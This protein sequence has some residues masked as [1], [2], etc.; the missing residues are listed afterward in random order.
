MDK[1]SKPILSILSLIT[2][3][4]IIVASYP[5]LIHA[6]FYQKE[7]DNWQVQSNGQ[8][9]INLFC[10]V[11]ALLIAAVFTL[12]NK[13]YGYLLWLGCLL[14]LVYT[15]TI[16]CFNIHF[17]QYFLI[18]CAILGLCFYQF[19]FILLKTIKTVYFKTG[20]SGFNRITGTYFLL[21]S[22]LFYTLWF[23]DIVPSLISNSV[24]VSL[25]EVGLFTNP[26]HVLDLSIFLPGIFIVGILIFKKMKLGHLMAPI[27]L[28]FFILMDVTIAILAILMNNNGLTDN[29]GVAFIMLIL[30]A[31]SALLLVRNLTICNYSYESN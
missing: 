30:A 27:I 15:Y 26:V 25:T 8:D 22:V 7:T 4:L 1:I 10:I 5:S 19:I 29:A 12:R 17:N 18:Y 2:C 31:F 11:P 21:I 6:D 3:L 16:Y 24:P 28:T 14:Y 9:I 13:A 23:K 20:A